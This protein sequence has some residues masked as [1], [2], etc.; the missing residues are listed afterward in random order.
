LDSVLSQVKAPTTIIWGEQDKVF[1]ITCAYDL[2][3][4]IA[5]SKLVLLHDVGHLPQLQASAKVAEIISEDRSL[6]EEW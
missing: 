4:G 3:T 2:H 5:N 6:R 1:P